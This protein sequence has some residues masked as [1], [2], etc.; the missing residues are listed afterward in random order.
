MTGSDAPAPLDRSRRSHARGAAAALW[1]ALLACGGLVACGGS[2]SAPSGQ[3]QAPAHVFLISLDTVPARAC[4]LYGYEKPTTPFLEEL[5]ARGVVFDAHVVNSNNTLVSHTSILTGLLPN[6]HGTY[7]HGADDRQALGEEFVTLAERF[8][9]AG[10]AT[11]AFTTHGTWLRGEW[12]LGQGFDT[13]ES[14]WVGAGRNSASFFRWYDEH[15]PQR[16]F[17]LLHYFD[18]HSDTSETY[19]AS[20]EYKQRF[21]GP[22]PADFTGRLEDRGERLAGTRYLEHHSSPD[23]PL[24]EEHVRYL[25]GLYDA[26]LAQLDERLRKLFDGLAER[27]LTDDALVVVTSDHG[28]EFKEHGWLLHRSF[29]EEIMHVPLLVVPPPGAEGAPDMGRPGSR[30]A[31]PTQ[32]IDIAPTLLELCGLDPLPRVQGRSFVPLLRGEELPERPALFNGIVVRGRDDASRFK[33]VGRPAAFHFY[34][35]D[36]DPGEALDLADDQRVLPRVER[37]YESLG[38]LLNESKR[39]HAEL[40]VGSGSGAPEATEEELKTL[41]DLGYLGDDTEERE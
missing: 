13:F 41:R 11:A 36:A 3:G 18:A 2:S 20:D 19:H 6:A 4:S 33:F 29:Y 5:A 39:I 12:G 15:R 8:Q 34:D 28:E 27:G 26:G 10:Y 24:P 9:D 22:A 25:R 37:A 40:S 14:R 21:A 35:L 38:V 23:R 7:D 17:V 1:A 30:V 31:A 16:S 32:S